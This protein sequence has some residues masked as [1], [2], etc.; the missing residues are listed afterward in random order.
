MRGQR[1]GGG[2]DRREVQSKNWK[3]YRNYSHILDSKPYEQR[4]RLSSPRRE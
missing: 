2:S 4:V 1:L 3:F